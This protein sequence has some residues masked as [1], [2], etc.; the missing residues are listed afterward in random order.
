MLVLDLRHVWTHQRNLSVFATI[1]NENF[2]QQTTK[3]I[4]KLYG[5][6]FS[7][8]ALGKTDR[9]KHSYFLKVY[10]CF[11]SLQNS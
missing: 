11:D 4:Q 1:F 8:S 7:E 9:N 2:Q 10:S 3:F 6:C 5:K